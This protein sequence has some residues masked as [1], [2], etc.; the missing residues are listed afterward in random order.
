MT[1]T[2]HTVE[3]LDRLGERIWN[4]ERLFNLKAGITFK[5]DTLPP[6]IL[7]EPRVKNRVVDIGRLLQEYY[8]WRG[9]DEKGVPSREKLQELGLE[10]EGTGV[11]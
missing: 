3:G 10:K 8:K 2:K 5:D 6:R 7:K 11:T 1:G 9:W 4:L